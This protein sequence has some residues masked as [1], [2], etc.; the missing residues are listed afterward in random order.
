ITQLRQA[1]ANLLFPSPPGNPGGV[2]IEQVETEANHMHRGSSSD[3]RV[4]KILISNRA[5]TRH[6]ESMIAWRFASTDEH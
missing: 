2:F 3:Y 6:T 1:K 4:V 5:Q